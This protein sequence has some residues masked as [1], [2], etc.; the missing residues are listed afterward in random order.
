MRLRLPHAPY[1]ASKIALDLVNCEYVDVEGEISTLKKIAQ[2]LLEADIKNEMHLEE[3]VHTILEANE[4]EIEFMRLDQRQLFRMAKKRVADEMGFLLNWEDRYNDLA[5]RTMDAMLK[6]EVIDFSVS[7]NRVK[8]II[9]KAIDGYLKSFEEIEDVVL[10]KI[11]H[12][13]RKLIPGTEEY[14]L[15]FQRLYEEELVKRGFG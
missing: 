2:E 11:E 10:E 15:V 7:E 3:K 9:F 5:H 14:D 1:I 12:Y 6:E 4:D 13:K 8:N